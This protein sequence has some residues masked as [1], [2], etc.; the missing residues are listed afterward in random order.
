[1]FDFGAVVLFVGI[2]MIGVGWETGIKSKLT[3]GGAMTLAAGYGIMSGGKSGDPSS[4]VVGFLML[5]FV[6]VWL[7]F[8]YKAGERQ[9]KAEVI[10]G[11]AL[12][13]FFVECVLAEANDFSKPKNV[14]R[15]KL[16]ADKYKL[17][18]PNGIEELYDRGL[19][20][21]KAVSQRFERN[22]LEEKR[23]EERKEFQRLN[24]YSDLTGKD[25]RITMLSAGLPS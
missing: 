7:V 8:G 19:E 4:I 16:L 14:Q 18:Y 6:I 24:Q 2:M 17:K 12:D 21:H 9:K 23:A 13:R 11:T 15:A 25:K 5:A 1:M 22:R 3:M 20:G 10:G